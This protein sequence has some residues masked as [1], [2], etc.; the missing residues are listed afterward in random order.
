MRATVRLCAA[1]LGGILGRDFIRSGKVN[2]LFISHHYRIRSRQ[3]LGYIG[4]FFE[5]VSGDELLDGRTTLVS[6]GYCWLNSR[7]LD[8]RAS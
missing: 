3:H 2:A 5:R 1:S 7:G 4:A 6:R 8:L